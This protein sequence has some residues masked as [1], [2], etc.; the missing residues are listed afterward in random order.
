MSFQLW[1]DVKPWLHKHA[2]QY[3][4]LYIHNLRQVGPGSK[5]ELCNLV[6]TEKAWNGSCPAC[7]VLVS[8]V[9][10]TLPC[11]CL[12]LALL[13]ACSCPVLALC[14]PLFFRVLRYACVLH[15]AF[16]V[17]IFVYKIAESFNLRGRCTTSLP[18]PAV[19]CPPAHRRVHASTGS[20]AP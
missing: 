16:F 2:L 8:V 17:E 14:L 1:S 9:C 10:L 20:A 5:I 7:P 13:V 18:S 4:Y 11:V 15:C 6:G 3:I 12:C 19:S